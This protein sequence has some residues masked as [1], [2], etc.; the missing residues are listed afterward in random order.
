MILFFNAYD[1]P[2][3]D[4]F[5]LHPYARQ[6]ITTVFNTTL[7][8]LFDKGYT[9]VTL[10]GT[11]SHQKYIQYY[12]RDYIHF[13]L[14]L[15]Y[16]KFYLTSREVKNNMSHFNAWITLEEVQHLQPGTRKDFIRINV[17]KSLRPMET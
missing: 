2:L 5:G 11:L 17:I 14:Q 6:A 16:G 10:C 4:T 1:R 13:S 9:Y 7:N 12:R 3:L 8:V 15:I